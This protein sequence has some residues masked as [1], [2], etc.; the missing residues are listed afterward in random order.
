MEILLRAVI[1]EYIDNYYEQD[2]EKT[3]KDCTAQALVCS[4][5]VSYLEVDY[6]IKEYPLSLFSMFR[7]DDGNI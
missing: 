3:V 5:R 4:E 7:C 1:T 6:V 2:K